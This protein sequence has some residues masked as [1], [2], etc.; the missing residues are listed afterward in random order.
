MKNNRFWMAVRLILGVA[1]L[2][3][4]ILSMVF[5]G[6]RYFLTLGLFMVAAANVINCM[7]G[8]KKRCRLLKKG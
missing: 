6:S 7:T 3:L 5:E 4:I 1:A 2:V 8:R